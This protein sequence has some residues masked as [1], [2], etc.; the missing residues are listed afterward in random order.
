MRLYRMT[1]EVLG[2]H[3]WS[4][5]K[6]RE[7][8]KNLC[9]HNQ[10]GFVPHP[11]VLDVIRLYQIRGIAP[12]FQMVSGVPAQPGRVLVEIPGP[13]KQRRRAKRVAAAAPSLD[14]SDAEEPP[15]VAGPLPKS[16]D[17]AAPATDTGGGTTQRGEKDKTN[18]CRRNVFPGL[19]SF[20]MV[21]ES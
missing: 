10:S 20:P 6:A 5:L 17:S 14:A 8:L 11:P 1:A 12:G 18:A 7:Y 9:Y 19:S 4:L 15:P 16:A 21:I 13:A 2:C 3:P